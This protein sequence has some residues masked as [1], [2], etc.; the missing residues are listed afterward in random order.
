MAMA[1]AA[2][3]VDDDDRCFDP[4]DLKMPESPEHRRVIDAIGIVA[5]RLL[6][7][8]VVVY[9]DM[10]WY[11]TDGGNAVAPDLMVLPA[12]A[13]V[14]RS[15]KQPTDGPVPSVVVEVPS[16]SDG[17][18][19]FLQK[20][21]RYQR[22][23]VCCYSVITGSGVCSVLRS[24]PGEGTANT[25]WTGEPIAELG[26]LRIDVSD[27][28]IVVVTPMGDV[29]V[30]DSDLV[31]AAEQRTTEAEYRTTESQQRVAELE[32]RLRAAGIEP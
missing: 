24:V 30:H 26:G 17:F 10:N 16:A 29:L 23:G 14:E 6:G 13:F 12:N 5:S 20:A 1:T 11:P 18:T 32:D 28:R 3:W 15:Y 4:D 8:D 22:L 27:D 9:R 2:Q 31:E 25:V 7:P 19:D 21:A